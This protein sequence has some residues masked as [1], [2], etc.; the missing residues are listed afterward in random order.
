MVKQSDW[1]IIYC[2]IKNSRSTHKRWQKIKKY[3][4]EENISFDFVQSEGET[5]VERLS[6]ML[7]ANGYHTILIVGGDAA[8]NAAVNGLM[9]SGI[10]Y[11]TVALGVIPNGFANDFARFWGYQ[12]KEYKQTITWLR[13]RRIRT[14]DVGEVHYTVEGKNKIIYFVDCINLGAAASIMN[15]RKKMHSF[16]G[17]RTLSFISSAFLLLFQR[18]EY[19]MH[20]KVNE[21]DFTKKVMTVC[22]GSASGY[23]QTPNA[24]PYNGLLDVSVVSHPEVAQLLQGLWLLF[25]GRFLTAS[26]VKS[27]RTKHVSILATS[28]ARIALDGK[29]LRELHPITTL[30]IKVKQEILNFIIP[31]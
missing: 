22:I 25:T 16:W 1:G 8:V 27:Y 9:N 15:L 19:K 12:E 4:E 5:S 29:V 31:S 24:V 10:D 23:G 3:L 14:I 13:E 7:A 6:S 20:L 11:T 28:K 2:P 21:D 26:N 18:M 30:E 17:F